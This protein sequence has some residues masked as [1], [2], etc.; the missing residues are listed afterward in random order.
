MAGW[1]GKGAAETIGIV[2]DS[3]C[4]FWTARKCIRG[5]PLKNSELIRMAVGY[6]SPAEGEATGVSEREFRL[7]RKLN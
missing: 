1:G 2:C 5:N 6:R 7:Q 3:R 4:A